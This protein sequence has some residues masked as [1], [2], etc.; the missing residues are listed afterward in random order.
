MKSNFFKSG[1]LSKFTQRM[2]CICTYC[3]VHSK[4]AILQA[5]H[6]KQSCSIYVQRRSTAIG[7]YTTKEKNETPKSICKSLGIKYARDFVTINYIRFGNQLKTN[8]KFIVGTELLVPATA[9]HHLDRID[10]AKPCPKTPPTSSKRSRPFTA[11]DMKVGDACSALWQG[12]WYDAVVLSRPCPRTFHLWE[13]QYLVD[14]TFNQLAFEHIRPRTAE[15]PSAK[16]LRSTL[17]ED[18]T[19]NYN[20]N[21]TTVVAAAAAAAA[22]A[23]TGNGHLLVMCDSEQQRLRVISKEL[24]DWAQNTAADAS[25]L[26]CSKEMNQLSDS[27][28]TTPIEMLEAIRSRLAWEQRTMLSGYLRTLIPQDRSCLTLTLERGA[29]TPVVVDPSIGPYLREAFAV[30]LSALSKK[31]QSRLKAT[32]QVKSGVIL[33]IPNCLTQQCV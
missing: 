14:R 32:G 18:T 13:V 23:V 12:V 20:F 29:L 31:D 9:H 24:H 19:A 7:T 22:A 3:G 2:S 21:S 26:A 4:N 6:H 30:P 8:S 27:S 25:H 15:H 1:C 5:T 16:R 33:S 28:S 11:G 17:S 10:A